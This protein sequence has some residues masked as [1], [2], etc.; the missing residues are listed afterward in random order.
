MKQNPFSIYDFLGYLIPGAVLLYS[1]LFILQY[2]NTLEFLNTNKN[3]TSFELLGFIPFVL[4]AYLLGHI[5]AICASIFIES[6]SNYKNGY[7]SSYLFDN[8]NISYLSC[9]NKTDNIKR[10]ILYIVIIPI[11]FLNT[12][13]V[14]WFNFSSLK[15]SKELTSPLK[16]VVFKQCCKILKEKFDIETDSWDLQAGI[17]GDQLRLLYHYSFEFSERHASKL[18]NYVSLYGFSRNIS[19]VFIILFWMSLFSVDCS[20]TITI[21]M[22]LIFGII[23][24]I[25]YIGF[26]KFYR[27]YSLETLMAACVIKN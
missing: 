8:Q 22:P 13:M 16:G 9:K 1:T 10:I 21:F 27:R 18:Q 15:Q 7:P 14:D 3:I 11:S 12:F 23:S 24:Y 20:N 26:V 4:L 25:F 6:F 5:L 2:K 19:F 17:A